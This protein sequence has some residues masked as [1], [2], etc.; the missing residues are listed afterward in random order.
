MYVDSRNSLNIIDTIEEKTNQSIRTY[1]DSHIHMLYDINLDED[2]KCNRRH[3]N[4]NFSINWFY[5]ARNFCKLSKSFSVLN[6]F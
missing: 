1:Y 3:L 4:Y 2:N 6:V 5:I